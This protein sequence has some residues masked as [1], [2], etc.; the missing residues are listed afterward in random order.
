MPRSGP[1]VRQGVS[2]RGSGGGCPGSG[3][4]CPQ[5][6]PAGRR[7]DAHSGM[8]AEESGGSAGKCPWWPEL[9]MGP[10]GDAGNSARRR[11]VRPR[12]PR[13]LWGSYG[14]RG[15]GQTQ[16]GELAAGP[17]KDSAGLAPGVGG[18]A[19]GPA[20]CLALVG[21]P[22]VRLGV[23]LLGG[24]ELGAR[25][26]RRGGPACLRLPFV[27]LRGCGGP[28]GAQGGDSRAVCRPGHEIFIAPLL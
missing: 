24:A 3:G 14:S 18:A 20:G 9:A 21:R 4:G 6:G 28:P 17:H 15:V 8:P 27:V 1:G 11:W 22:W 23:S 26:V 5:R 19:A 10:V 25:G 12:M 2:G 16:P 7:G 13:L